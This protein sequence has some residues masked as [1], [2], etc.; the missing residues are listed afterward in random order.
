MRALGGRYFNDKRP[1]SNQGVAG[2]DKK[3]FSPVLGQITDCPL[4]PPT[5]PFPL[6]SGFSGWTVLQSGI[7]RR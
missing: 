3:V 4:T 5:V 7:P 2:R 1:L 6:C